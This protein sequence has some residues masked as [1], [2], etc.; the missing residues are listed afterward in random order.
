MRGLSGS[1]AG[2]DSSDSPLAIISSL[3][4]LGIRDSGF[5][6]LGG[7]ESRVPSPESR[8]AVRS[9]APVCGCGGSTGRTATAS[10]SARGGVTAKPL[11]SLIHTPVIS[12]VGVRYTGRFSYTGRPSYGFESGAN[13]RWSRRS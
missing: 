7:F 13:T 6:E 4:A 1:L 2:R 11:E 12:H 8:L 3:S 5:G 10:E 9:Y